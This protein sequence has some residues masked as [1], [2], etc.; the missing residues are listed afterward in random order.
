MFSNFLTKNSFW[1]DYHVFCIVVLCVF[2][3]AWK[4]DLGHFINR[5]ICVSLKW[6]VP[7]FSFRGSHA[8][9][10]QMK[11]LQW[12]NQW[13]T[14]LNWLILCQIITLISYLNQNYVVQIQ[15]S[16]NKLFTIKALT[17]VPTYGIIINQ[18]SLYETQNMW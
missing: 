3:K 10:L 5:V 15:M 4:N 14:L 18:N 1:L 6:N 2:P 17:L 8:C 9:A 11:A 12:L 13:R 7:I 16:Q